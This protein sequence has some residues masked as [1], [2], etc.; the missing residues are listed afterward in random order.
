MNLQLKGFTA[1]ET[2]T[3]GARGNRAAE[4][5]L[6]A[7]KSTKAIDLNA[8][9]IFV[10]D[11]ALED[12]AKTHRE[13]ETVEIELTQGDLWHLWQH[14]DPERNTPVQLIQAAG[15]T[16][17]SVRNR[18]ADGENGPGYREVQV[19]YTES[20]IANVLNIRIHEGQAEAEI[21]FVAEFESYVF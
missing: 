5:L 21:E 3:S 6:A 20:V 19:E 12:G 14:I 16:R 11:R 1:A 9:R 10:R 2:E 7:L 8:M 4:I 17:E 13:V 15:S 18:N